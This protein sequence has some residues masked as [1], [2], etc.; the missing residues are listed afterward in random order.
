[1]K[2]ETV[3]S[4]RAAKLTIEGARFRYEP[5]GANPVETNC[6][7]REFSLEQVHPRAYSVL[8][9]GRSFEV[10]LGSGNESLGVG[11]EIVINGRVLCVEVFD[12]RGMRGRRAA[13]A[14]SGRQDIAS[15][16]PGKVVRVLVAPG[17]AV[18]AGQGLIVVEAMK[19][20]NEMKSPKD[21]R[22]AEVKATTGA[23]VTAGQVL[24]VI[25]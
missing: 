17:D 18:E 8:V 10:I 20:Q 23:A 19:M 22:V 14:M 25:E 4:G 2:F 11:N 16:M 15:P 9:G 13:G 1:V 21:G 6:V 3:V 7:E 5:E 12:P 24:V